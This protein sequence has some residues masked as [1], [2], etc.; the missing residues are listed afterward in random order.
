MGRTTGAT[1]RDVAQP[2]DGD[3]ARQ[4]RRAGQARA[5]RDRLRMARRLRHPGAARDLRRR[6]SR[7]FFRGE[8]MESRRQTIGIVSVALLAARAANVPIARM[9]S[10]WKAN[11]LAQGPLLIRQSCTT[12]WS[13]PDCR[14]STT[15]R[16]LIRLVPGSEGGLAT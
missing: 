11:Q 6:L 14:R 4:H 3:L 7:P 5:W 13:R 16:S 15:S 10:G 12:Y 9:T 8:I 2:A 1:H